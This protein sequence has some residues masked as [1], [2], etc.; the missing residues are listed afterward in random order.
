MS[1][2]LACRNTR[3]LNTKT[4]KRLGLSLNPGATVEHILSTLHSSFGGGLGYG[5]YVDSTV[6]PRWLLN[7]NNSLEACELIPGEEIVY[8]KLTRTMR[9]KNID[10]NFITAMLD[11]T[12]SLSE[13]GAHLLEP[14][15]LEWTDEYGFQMNGKV[16]LDSKLSLTDHNVPETDTLVFKRKFWFREPE[17]DLNCS[18]EYLNMLL[19]QVH[20]AISSDSRIL[21][22]KVDAAKLAAIYLAVENGTMDEFQRSVANHSY[23]DYKHME[24][25][26]TKK[27]SQKVYA[28][29]PSCWRESK[30]IVGEAMTHYRQLGFPTKKQGKMVYVK[31][32]FSVP[33]FGAFLFIVELRDG[34][35]QAQ[36][37]SLY[38]EGVI[39]AD[40]LKNTTLKCIPWA[41]IKRWGHS[42]DTVVFDCLDSKYTF[43]TIEGRAITVLCNIVVQMAKGERIERQKTPKANTS[44]PATYIAPSEE[45]YVVLQQPSNPSQLPTYSLINPTQNS[46]TQQEIPQM[47]SQQ[48]APSKPLRHHPQP[49]IPQPEPSPIIDSS[50]CS[51][52][53]T[54]PSSS[55]RAECSFLTHSIPTAQH[56]PDP[57][58]FNPDPS[59]ELLQPTPQPPI[60]PQSPSPLASSLPEPF[61]P[62]GFPAI[63]TYTC[64]GTSGN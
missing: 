44:I 3:D 24:S 15:N 32:A 63:H 49:Q 28:H 10:G 58:A 39:F 62:T 42:A 54:K 5:L 19:F 17:F 11:N 52:L 53:P 47:T 23:T 56:N 61:P 37:I 60:I 36:Y 4:T 12:T 46:S 20:E 1:I 48:P 43:T 7:P 59:P 30:S 41:N 57:P 6:R 26:F 33:S 31:K 29:L 8:L 27:L 45:T 16:W 51:F 21:P 2:V 25:E 34:S 9:V 64:Y 18:E 13:I 14:F 35:R 22:S 38:K 50:T 55:N 40:L